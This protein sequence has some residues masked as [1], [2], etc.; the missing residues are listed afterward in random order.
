MSSRL[1]STPGDDVVRPMVQKAVGVLADRPCC[2]ALRARVAPA[3]ELYFAQV[4]VVLCCVEV[5]FAQVC[6]LC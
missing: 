2:G 1:L 5:Y 6:V 3:A 4:C